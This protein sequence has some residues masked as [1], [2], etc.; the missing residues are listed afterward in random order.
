M[1]LPIPMTS[2]FAYDV[3][4]QLFAC[5]CKGVT[6]MFIPLV[7]VTLT[8]DPEH[9]SKKLTIVLFLSGVAN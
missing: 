5:L 8:F 2:S 3:L 6:G 9:L 4:L 7:S 1:V